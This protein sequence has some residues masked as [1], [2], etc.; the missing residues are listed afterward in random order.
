[1]VFMI[2]D[3]FWMVN[4]KMIVM[5][6]NF[7]HINTNFLFV[8]TLTHMGQC[9]T[10]LP[11]L[12]HMGQCWQIGVKGGTNYWNATSWYL[13]WKSSKWSS[14]VIQRD[15]IIPNMIAFNFSIGKNINQFRREA[16]FDV[17]TLWIDRNCHFILKEDNEWRE[18]Q[19]K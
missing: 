9:W 19:W 17:K 5:Q 16:I 11:T 14:K 2:L 8:P 1:M 10:I 3:Q 18:K 15:A 12:T 13:P 4:P 6:A 7:Y